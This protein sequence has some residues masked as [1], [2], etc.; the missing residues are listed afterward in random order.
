MFVKKCFS[1]EETSIISLIL[2]E[3]LGKIMFIDKATESL[4]CH[5]TDYIV[6]PARSR[7]TIQVHKTIVRLVSHSLYQ[8]F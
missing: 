4:G 1:F 7:Y 5:Q 8:N 2:R 3:C 6:E